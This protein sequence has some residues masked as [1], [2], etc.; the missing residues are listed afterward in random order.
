MLV[1]RREGKLVLWSKVRL[2]WSQNEL[3]NARRL[4]NITGQDTRDEGRIYSK[5]NIGNNN[6]TGPVFLNDRKFSIDKIN[7]DKTK[8]AFHKL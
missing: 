1:K 2:G 7:R 8:N 4:H 3:K 5:I 6:E